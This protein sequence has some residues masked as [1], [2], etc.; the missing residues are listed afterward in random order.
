MTSGQA[1]NGIVRNQCRGTMC[2]RGISMVKLIFHDAHKEQVGFHTWRS[3]RGELKCAT[4]NVVNDV[5]DPG[6]QDR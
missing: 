5:T 1:R 2:V 6:L 3:W 4:L